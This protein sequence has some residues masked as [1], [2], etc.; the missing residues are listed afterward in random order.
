MEIFRIIEHES[1]Q[2]VLII[3]EH[4]SVGDRI[5]SG[6]GR[7]MNI[8]LRIQRD[9]VSPYIMRGF[10]LMYEA[11]KFVGFKLWAYGKFR[12]A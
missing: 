9:N 1:V 3:I 10:G 6:C 5:A 12:R 8:V 11:S 7:L 4:E 2:V